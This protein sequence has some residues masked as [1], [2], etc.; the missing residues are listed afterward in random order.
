MSAKQAERHLVRWR[1]MDERRDPLVRQAH[2]A[3]ISIN[4]IHTLTGI[5]RSTIYRI[6]DKT[7]PTKQPRT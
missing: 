4:R 1:Q 6:L 3:G 7:E 2:A 5:G